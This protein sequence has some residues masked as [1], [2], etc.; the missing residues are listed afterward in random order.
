MSDLHKTQKIGEVKEVFDN[1]TTVI[2]VR[3]K[4]CEKCKA[5]GMMVGEN[6][7]I[8]RAVNNIGANVGD[9][10][11]VEFATKNSL[12]SSVYAYLLP[13]ATLFAGLAVGYNINTSFDKQVVA[14]LCGIAGVAIGFCVLRILN[15]YF[16]RKFKNIY[17]IIS[18]R[19]KD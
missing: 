17:T 9:K 2:F 4:S 19:E 5:C 6:K 15:P 12:L 8:V 13:L 1:R 14:A 3:S 18:V 11:E 16:K 10:V 7:I